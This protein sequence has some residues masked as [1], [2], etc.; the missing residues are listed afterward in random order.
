MSG[1]DHG[2]RVDQSTA[3]NVH[4]LLRVLLEDGHLPRVLACRANQLVNI[5]RYETEIKGRERKNPV[6]D[7]IT[8]R[9]KL[10]ELAVSVHVGGRLDPAG[11]AVRVPLAA[12][13]VAADVV[14][15]RAGGV[16]GRGRSSAA[17]LSGPA[18]AVGRIKRLPLYR[19]HKP[20]VSLSAVRISRARDK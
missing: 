16:Y 10:T 8:V 4:A 20:S 14:G 11:D 7:V 5:Y 2:P 9:S 3:A 17:H 18:T 13:S 19:T 6:T 1:R 15:R 12:L